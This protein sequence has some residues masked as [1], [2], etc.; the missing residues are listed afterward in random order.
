MSGL[1]GLGIIWKEDGK[2][3][4]PAPVFFQKSGW[5]M[6]DT[7][8]SKELILEA[9]PVSLCARTRESKAMLQLGPNE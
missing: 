8:V 2:S 1:T 7:G 9:I 5:A 6:V 4:A 3:T